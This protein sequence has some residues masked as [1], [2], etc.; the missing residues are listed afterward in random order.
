M[1]L[2]TVW[3]S[4]IPFVPVFWTAGINFVLEFYSARIGKS[5]PDA[6]CFVA[7]GNIGSR[8]LEC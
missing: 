7:A 5:I 1:I 6:G 2:I 4:T 8:A 3:L